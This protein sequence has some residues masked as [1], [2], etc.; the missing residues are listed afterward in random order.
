MHFALLH[1][2]HPDATDLE[3]CKDHFT[4]CLIR[5]A[6]AFVTDVPVV[7]LN[8][9]VCCT[10]VKLVQLEGKAQQHYCLDRE[11][12]FEA[13]QRNEF[14]R[15]M[16]DLNCPSEDFDTWLEQVQLSYYRWIGQLPCELPKRK[17]TDL[18]HVLLSLPGLQKHLSSCQVWA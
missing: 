12:W 4:D 6:C 1:D 14:A 7:R 2:T 13:A 8:N 15:Y 17:K 18:Q 9:G 3:D 16:Q 11:L 5:E 10:L